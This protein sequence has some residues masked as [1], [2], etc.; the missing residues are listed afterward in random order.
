MSL[1]FIRLLVVG[2]VAMYFSFD[3]SLAGACAA[4][5]PELSVE[6]QLQILVALEKH[7]QKSAAGERVTEAEYT[8]LVE[9]SKGVTEAV[10]PELFS[11]ILPESG[12]IERP[13]LFRAALFSCLPK[14]SKRIL[15]VRIAQQYI[16]QPKGSLFWPCYLVQALSDIGERDD[17]ALVSRLGQCKL[18]S[19]F[20]QAAEMISA[21]AQYEEDKKYFDDLMEHGRAV[22]LELDSVRLEEYR[23]QMNSR[24][25]A[26]RNQPQ[27]TR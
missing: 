13:H 26:K 14:G 16:T 18:S 19:V 20:H 22:K 9:R 12:P 8:E 2:F 25:E 3:V 5:R 17:L 24:V 27:E 23:S 7:F 1:T 6:K 11:R 21:T 10:L 15:T 4:T